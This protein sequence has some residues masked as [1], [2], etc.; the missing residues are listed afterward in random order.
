M[1]RTTTAAAALFLASGCSFSGLSIVGGYTF[2]YEGLVAERQ[3]AGP[4]SA[5]PLEVTVDHLFGEVDVA[6][7][8]AGEAT[9][10]AWTIQA[11]AGDSE[12]AERFANEVQLRVTEKPG[13]IDFTLDVPQNP[14]RALR[15][16]KSVL[17]LRLDPGSDL[18][19][20]NRHAV[21]RV[22]GLEGIVRLETAHGNSHVSH[23]AQGY[24]GD[25]RH[26]DLEVLEVGSSKI[27]LAH[28]D[29]R[30]E[31]IEGD[32]VLLSEHGDLV[33]NLVH[34]DTTVSVQHG[35]LDFTGL[36]RTQVRGNHGEWRLELVDGDLDLQ[37]A[38]GDVQVFMSEGHIQG[39]VSHGDFDLRALTLEGQI[40]VQHGD[41]VLDLTADEAITI[42]AE[43]SYGDVEGSRP[44]YQNGS[45]EHAQLVLRASHGDVRVD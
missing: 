23:L 22:D 2:D 44:T 13:G 45:K 35:D 41:L 27:E 4:L 30:L 26:G 21:S 9:G 18:V 15:G 16:L 24:E 34:G 32:L 38:H 1:L 33:G 5:A 20:A 42:A 43:A 28:G 17:T 36:H 7:A 3:E 39:N 10:W 37:H 14:G 11:W 19:L 40:A 29:A 25:H 12:V 8:K 31:S 6:A